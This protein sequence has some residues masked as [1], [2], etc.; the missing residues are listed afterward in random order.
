MFV[1]RRQVFSLLLAF[2]LLLFSLSLT[3]NLACAQIPNLRFLFTVERFY[4]DPLNSPVG[5]FVDNERGEIYVVDSGRDEVAIFDNKG[6]PLFRFG[7]AQGIANPLDLVVRDGQIYLTQEGKGYIEVFS[8]RGEA[9]GRVL[10]N[11][12]PF[13]PG[14]LTLD[15]EGNLYVV[16]KAQTNCLVFND[17]DNLIRVIGEGLSSISGVAVAKDRIYL[18]TPFNGHAIQV[19]DKKG[20]Y[21]MGFEGLQDRGGTLGLPI[22]AQVDRNGLLWLVDA[23]KGIVLYDS[24]GVEVKRFSEYGTSKGQLFFPEDIDFF[25]RGNMVYIA[26]KGAKRVSVFKR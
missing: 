10:P 3:P 23:L 25:D 6:I 15:E 2:C 19:Y 17:K 12:I 21:I 20:D 8:H 13:S 5:L 1:V 18:V 16:N 11:G 14:R 24:H 7:R 9:I 26:E 4:Q 22:S